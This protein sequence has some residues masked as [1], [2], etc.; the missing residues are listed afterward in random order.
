MWITQSVGGFSGDIRAYVIDIN[1]DGMAGPNHGGAD[2]TKDFDG[3]VGEG[4]WSDGTT[5]WVSSGGALLAYNLATKVRD[6][7][8]DFVKLEVGAQGIWSDG[9]I[10]WM[11]AG[12]EIHAYYFPVEPVIQ[13]MVRRS[14]IPATDTSEPDVDPARAST[15]DAGQ[16]VAD[17]VDPD[18]GQD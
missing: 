11:V 8:K 9:R 15:V 18:G 5:L 17:I 10:M 13:T 14:T 4:I 12:N 2:S 7:N 16:C 3:I 1:S 6:P